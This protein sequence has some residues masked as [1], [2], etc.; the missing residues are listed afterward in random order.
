M[1]WSVSKQKPYHHNT[2]KIKKTYLL[3]FGE[4][5]WQHV[6]RNTYREMDHINETLNMNDYPAPALVDISDLNT[7]LNEYK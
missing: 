5:I 1:F 6:T 7:Y 4:S 3:P 2:V